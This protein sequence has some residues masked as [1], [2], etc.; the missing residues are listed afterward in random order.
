MGDFHLSSL[1]GW[2]YTNSK[3]K[4]QNS[5][6]RKPE[7]SRFMRLELLLNFTELVLSVLFHLSFVI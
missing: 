5:K 3:F 7:F 2:Q 4:I 6:L 1:A